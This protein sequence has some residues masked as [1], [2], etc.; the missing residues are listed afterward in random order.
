MMQRFTGWVR[1]EFVKYTRVVPRVLRGMR[2]HDSKGVLVYST[3]TS[4]SN[5]IS[6][7][8]ELT[9]TLPL[10]AFPFRFTAD[11]VI[12]DFKGMGIGLVN[13]DFLW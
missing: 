10:L 13:R 1:L 7:D 6:V 2:A 9:V 4:S 12:M 3:S 11:L 8:L 5:A